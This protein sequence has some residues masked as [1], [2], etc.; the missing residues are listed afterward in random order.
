MGRIM[1]S[2]VIDD[3]IPGS[4]FEV[5]DPRYIGV[6]FIKL[7]GAGVKRATSSLRTT[8]CAV[9]ATDNTSFPAGTLH[10][11]DNRF[12][13]KPVDVDIF[14]GDKCVHRTWTYLP[15]DDPINV[16]PPLTSR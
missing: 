9:I 8:Q 7:T 6:W 16:E 4:V 10:G 3:L 13:I 15:Y 1:T 14:Q 2:R 11:L 5:E 12:D